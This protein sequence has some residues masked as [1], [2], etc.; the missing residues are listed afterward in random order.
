MRFFLNQRMIVG[1]AHRTARRG[2]F[3]VRGFTLVEL[4]VV[5]AII[6]VLVALLLPAIQ[7]AREAARRT[8]CGNNLH[9]I[10][11][12]L[13]GHVS[14]RKAF[15]SGSEQTC[16]QCDPWNWAAYTL[17]YMEENQIYSQLQLKNDPTKAPNTSGLLDVIGN[18]AGPT[19]RIVKSYL[20]PSAGRFA[21]GRREDF[22]IKVGS[23]TITRKDPNHIGDIFPNSGFA[24]GNG[25]GILN[26][27]ELM[28]CM[29]YAGNDGP[30]SGEVIYGRPGVQYG[31]NLGVLLSIK[32]VSGAT[33]GL[34]KSP[35]ISP[36]QI[37]DGLSKTMMVFELTGRGY[38]PAKQE[39]R[40]TW[41]DGYNVA[42]IK[43]N[44]NLPGYPKDPN[45][46]ASQSA[47]NTD[48]IFSDHSGGAGMVFCDGSYHFLIETTDVG[49]LFALSSRNQGEAIP[50]G[51]W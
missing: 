26:P 27:G 50:N 15:P 1:D 44:I 42:A 48:E 37:T 46:F 40:G 7:A 45:D 47:W 28:A 10:A 21:M 4:L 36:K 43:L 16:Y 33:A 29:D 34:A 12:G 3:R 20:C 2:G 17:P 32:H 25:N 14:A 49:I 8:S 30:S 22:S 39:L 41:A 51:G 18:P 31:E 35:P 5:I 19:Q 11:I 23:V 9:N 13:Q 6:G 24:T 38:H